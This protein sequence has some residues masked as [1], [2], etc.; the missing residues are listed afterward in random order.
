MKGRHLSL[1]ALV[2]AALGAGFGVACSGE[3]DG[4][5][6]IEG[7]ETKPD[8]GDADAGTDGGEIPGDAAADGPEVPTDGSAG[9]LCTVFDRIVPSSTDFY[10]RVQLAVG[11]TG[12]G[13]VLYA[14]NGVSTGALVSGVYDAA[15]G[16]G[17][18]PQGAGVRRSSHSLRHDVFRLDDGSLRL[19][20]ATSHESGVELHWLS[21]TGT[22]ERT[23]NPPTSRSSAI[24]AVLQHGDVTYLAWNQDRVLSGDDEES[25]WIAGYTPQG[26]AFP[27]TKLL[28]DLTNLTVH[29][30]STP[31]S[32][33]LVWSGRG[34]GEGYLRWASVSPQ[35]VVG[36]TVTASDYAP[37]FT[38]V[39]RGDELAVGYTK[40]TRISPSIR[41]QVVLQ[42]FDFATGAGRASFTS[43]TEDERG[44]ALSIRDDGYAVAFIG[45]AESVG[46]VHY[47]HLSPTFDIERRV[48]IRPSATGTSAYI[49]NHPVDLAV[50]GTSAY[51][52]YGD[53]NRR[54][55]VVH[56]T[57]PD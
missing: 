19:A 40:L 6:P 12:V 43:A 56:V 42:S 9:D 25:L 13:S 38:V 49:P 33:H 16:T 48:I 29:W 23:E 20:T 39:R 22:L 15:L 32:A 31:S 14:A 8:G 4:A 18:V 47:L 17:A 45:D 35:G 10:E 54:V 37:G 44:P 28:G 53:D 7:S 52:A 1:I 50:H 55:H 46:S 51:L 2:T 41:S 3:E 24:P 57:C 21:P 36:A 26:E 30:V 34:G 27:P 11:A 5:G